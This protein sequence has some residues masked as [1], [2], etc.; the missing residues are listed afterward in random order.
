[1]SGVVEPGTRRPAFFI[2]WNIFCL[3]ASQKSTRLL[4]KMGTRK[5]SI[6]LPTYS[7]SEPCGMNIAFLSASELSASAA[8]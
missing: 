2:H 3:S 1:M 6:S 5:S 8:S 7:M 4:P